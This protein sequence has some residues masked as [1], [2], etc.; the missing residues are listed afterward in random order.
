MVVFEN[1]PA[2]LPMRLLAPGYRHC[3]CLLSGGPN[4]IVCDPLKTRIEVTQLQGI[5]EEALADHYFR[6]G[7]RVLLGHPAVPSAT[8]RLQLRPLTCVEVVKRLLNIDAP[9]VFT[10]Y[11]LYRKLI[12]STLSFVPY[13]L[14]P[15]IPPIRLDHEH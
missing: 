10:P 9:G 3:F 14:D 8:A 4:W 15:A 6:T 11:Q 5:D 13:P 7:R 2:G 12:K 1:R